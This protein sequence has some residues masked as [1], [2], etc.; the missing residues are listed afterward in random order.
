MHTHTSTL[1]R[2]VAAVLIAA[3]GVLHLALAGDQ[4][5]EARYV[6][7]LFI[8]GGI[9]ALVVALWLWFRPHVGMWTLGAIIAAG[10]FVGFILSRTVGLPNFKEPEWELSGIVSLLLEGGYLVA[11]AAWFGAVGRRTTAAPRRGT[12]A[13]GRPVSPRA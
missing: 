7:V 11:M 13:R 10:M 6:G 9:G 8:A 4:M 12:V 5:Q 1:L 2:R 3:V